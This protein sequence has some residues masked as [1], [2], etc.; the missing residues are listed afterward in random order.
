MWTV[1]PTGFAKWAPFEFVVDLFSYIEGIV[2][3]M[4]DQR[5]D[6]HVQDWS[7]H[8]G[9]M[10]KWLIV[11]VGVLCAALIILWL[12]LDVY[13]CSVTRLRRPQVTQ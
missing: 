6:I 1:M 11:A 3:S 10:T 2:N 4:L 13:R 7:S 9:K 12:R 5:A 8:P